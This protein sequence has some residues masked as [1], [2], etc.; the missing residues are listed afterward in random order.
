MAAKNS[1]PYQGIPDDT[2]VTVAA[3]KGKEI[4]IKDMTYF[5]A[6]K[7]LEQKSK[8]KYQIYQKGFCSLKERKP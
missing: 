2:I 5:E 8:Y 7:K 6:K 3:F 1:K 4:A